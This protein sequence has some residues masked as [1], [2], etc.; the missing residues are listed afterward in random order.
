[1]SNNITEDR[2]VVPGYPG[3]RVNRLGELQTAYKMVGRGPGTGRGARNRVV[4]DSWEPMKASRLPS[5]YLYVHV[6][7]RDEGVRRRRILYLHRLVAA[8][9]LGPC[10]DGQEVLH[11]D[12]NPANNRLDNLSY[13]TRTNNAADQLRHGT[14]PIGSRH[15][16]AK[17]NEEKVRDVLELLAQNVPL[18]QIAQR[19]GVC[20][21]TILNI[22]RRLTWRHVEPRSYQPLA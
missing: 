15:G 10:P 11:G 9:F 20:Y 14:R 7:D 4:G 17:L 21:D 22:K 19:F 3:L 8:A 5:G 2:R 12:G 18:S 16:I 6:A 13:G 1:M